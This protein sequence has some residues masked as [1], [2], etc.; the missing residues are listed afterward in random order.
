MSWFGDG[1]MVIQ[2]SAGKPT[3]AHSEWLAV[4]QECPFLFIRP[5]ST[6]CCLCAYNGARAYGF[7]AKSDI[8]CPLG[9]PHLV[10]KTCSESPGTDNNSAVCQG[11]TKDYGVEGSCGNSEG[12]LS[13]QGKGGCW[14][15]TDYKL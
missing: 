11:L 12:P 2:D 8:P 3:A 7:T 13:H 4:A 6:T 1:V 9:A 14:E 10:V 15:E 5:P